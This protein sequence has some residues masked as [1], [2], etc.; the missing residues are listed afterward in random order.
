EI[1][2]GPQFGVYRW[3]TPVCACA[4]ARDP[5]E[6]WRNRRRVVTEGRVD[7]TRGV[8]DHSGPPIAAAPGASMN[9]LVVDDEPVV[10]RAVGR[11]IGRC[12]WDARFTWASSLSEAERAMGETPH[13]VVTIDLALTPNRD[14]LRGIRL[15]E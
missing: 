6:G 3:D 9:V 1:D 10:R 14:R 15:L 4:R 13:D 11:A 2:R 8:V 7:G 5:I 12:W